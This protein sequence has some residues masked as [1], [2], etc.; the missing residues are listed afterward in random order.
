MRGAARTTMLENR[1]DA[2]S[3]F[4]VCYRCSRTHELVIRRVQCHGR[5]IDVPARG[6]SCRRCG[7][8]LDVAHV[9]REDEQDL[10]RKKQEAEYLENLRRAEA[11]LSGRAS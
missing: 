9:F 11:V 1:P 7:T 5:F 8:S 2:P 3:G 4:A 10:V 6:Q